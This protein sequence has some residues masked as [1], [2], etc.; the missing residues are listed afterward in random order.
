MIYVIYHKNCI[1]GICA[2]ALIEKYIGKIISFA[3]DY[4]NTFPFDPTGKDVI[5]VDFSF[6]R[7]ILI[8]AHKKANTLRVFDHHISAQNNCKG[9][10]FCKFDMSE[11]GSML[12]CNYINT[13]NT[14]VLESA[15]IIDYVNDRDLWLWNLD[16]S[17]EVSTAFSSYP[18]TIDEWIEI[19][20][21]PVDEF[22][23]EG[24]QILKYQNQIIKNII[25]NSLY[26]TDMLE[27]N[28]PI[29]NSSCFESEI[30]NIICED[31]P[32]GIVYYETQ[33]KNVW[34]VS[35][36]SDE[37]G[38]NVC[39][40]AKKF[41]GGGHKHAAGFYVKDKFDLTGIV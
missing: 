30:G 36:R 19:L 13:I 40:L 33:Y 29:I 24:K 38:I 8:D 31:E 15:K 21:R 20:G 7:N 32:F 35:L 12:V 28:V 23:V 9:L 39:E 14:K 25:N 41:N 27:F 2:A 1:D 18:K 16:N 4:E 11:S 3:C 37:N 17:K 10:D 5:I 22:I 6:A 26:F 34:K